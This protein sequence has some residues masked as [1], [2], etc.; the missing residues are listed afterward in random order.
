MRIWKAFSYGVQSLAFSPDGAVL[1]CA[2]ATAGVKLFDVPTGRELWHVN[3]STS[4]PHVR[5]TPDGEKVISLVNQRIAVLSAADGRELA[6]HSRMLAGFAVPP[7]PGELLAVTAAMDTPEFRRLNLADGA[8]LWKKVL[9]YHGGIK[10][11]ELSPDARTLGTVSDR[12]ALLIDA[13]ARKLLYAHRLKADARRTPVLAFAP[14]GRA[15]VFAEKNALRTCAVGAPDQLRD[16]PFDG[17]AFH[18]LAFK[19]D[20]RGLFAVRGTSQVEELNAETW[21]PT[22]AWGWKAGKLVRVAVSPD[23]AL[24]AAGS[25]TGHAVVWDVDL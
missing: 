2:S 10:R 5:F 7:E 14:S 17:P 6:R 25:D 9:Q 21:E 1:A 23:G 15:F 4:A 22:N 12:E 18:D 16:K 8:V 11:I 13:E 24:A 20:G 3:E 19:R